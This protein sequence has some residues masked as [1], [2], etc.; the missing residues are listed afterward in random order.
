MCGGVCAESTIGGGRK[1]AHVSV[2]TSGE[3]NSFHSPW[4]LSLSVSVSLSL[5]LSLSDNHKE[6]TYRMRYEEKEEVETTMV[7][8][9]R[10]SAWARRCTVRCAVLRRGWRACERRHPSSRFVV[11]YRTLE[12]SLDYSY[13]KPRVSLADE[14]HAML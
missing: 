6:K 4:S 3:T 7:V 13:I 9:T 10:E 11:L 8:S 2:D 1:D 14:T 5:C 12:E